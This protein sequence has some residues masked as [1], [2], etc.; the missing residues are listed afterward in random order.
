M[1]NISL[2]KLANAIGCAVADPVRPCF[3]ES[4]KVRVC[5]RTNI[6]VSFLKNDVRDFGEKGVYICMFNPDLAS[7]HTLNHV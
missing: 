1:G 4:A 3:V 5:M 7:V 2:M 6:G